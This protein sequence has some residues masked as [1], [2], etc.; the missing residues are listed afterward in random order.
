MDGDRGYLAEF[1]KNE[2]QIMI[3]LPYYL[4][5]ENSNNMQK[6]KEGGESVIIVY[7]DAR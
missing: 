6:R 4:W 5:A 7:Q 1:G 3:F 2:T